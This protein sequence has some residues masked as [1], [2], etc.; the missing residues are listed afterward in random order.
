MDPQALRIVSLLRET[1]I[2]IAAT[3]PDQWLGGVI[4]ALEA[5]PAIR[6]VRVGREDDGVGICAGAYLGGQRAV[7][8]CQSAGLL[9]S[10]NALAGY[11][12][13]HQTPFL[14]LAALRGGHDDAY[15][16]Q[17]YKHRVTVP[18]LDAL[19][20]PHHTLSTPQDAAIIPDAARQAWLSRRP[21]VLLAHRD[22]LR[23]APEAS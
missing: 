6:L 19:G 20:L 22:A 9:L 10:A 1:G 3:L 12:Q 4:S 14:V 5:E 2:T 15:Y 17:T 11:A 13:H 16:Y 23:T 18:V 21:V 7:L 8:V